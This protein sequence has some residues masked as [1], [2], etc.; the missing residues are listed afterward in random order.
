VPALLTV[1]LV[2][3]TPVL[4]LTVPTQPVAV[5]VAVSELHKLFFVVD[6]TGDAGALPVLIIISFDFG[7]TPH[8]VS[9][10]TE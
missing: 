4:H 9:H 10:T 5:N 3:L 7:L 2:A 8:I 6:I 1:M